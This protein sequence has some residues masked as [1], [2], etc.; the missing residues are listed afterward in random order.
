LELLAEWDPW[1]EC[2]AA[3]GAKATKATIGTRAALG[4]EDV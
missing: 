4:A 3:G 2:R 1:R